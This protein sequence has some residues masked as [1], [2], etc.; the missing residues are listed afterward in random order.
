MT[1][2]LFRLRGYLLVWGMGAEA[3]MKRSGTA[4]K[5]EICSIGDRVARNGQAAVGCSRLDKQAVAP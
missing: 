5:L 2:H 4:I 1:D 3:P